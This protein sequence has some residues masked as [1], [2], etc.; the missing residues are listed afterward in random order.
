MLIWLLSYAFFW[1]LLAAYMAYTTLDYQKRLQRANDMVENGHIYEK[2]LAVV[3]PQVLIGVLVAVE[4][5]VVA[6]DAYGFLLAGVYTPLFDWQKFL[7]GA[8]LV[9][10]ACEC[11]RNFS[12]L[13]KFPRIFERPEPFMIMARYLRFCTTIGHLSTYVANYGK[14]FIAVRLFLTVIT[15]GMVTD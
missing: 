13:R 14:C 7:F 6:V 4:L 1:M 5:F 12:H 8:V 2:I 11:L 15:P 10:Y 3:S 9:A